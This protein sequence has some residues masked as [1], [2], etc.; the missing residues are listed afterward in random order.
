MDLPARPRGDRCPGPGGSSRRT[1]TNG[2]KTV[3][4]GLA[5]GKRVRRPACASRLTGGSPPN[6]PCARWRETPW[7]VKGSA[8]DPAKHGHL[9]ELH[10]PLLL[11]L[12]A[13]SSIASPR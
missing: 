10:R 8:H 2:E 4:V 7:G 13:I 3:N 9:S 6:V 11:R 5:G 12:S 1:L